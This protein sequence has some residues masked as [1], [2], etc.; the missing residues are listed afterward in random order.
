MSYTTKTVEVDIELDDFDD[1]DIIEYLQERGYVV[2]NGTFLSREEE[3]LLYELYLDYVEG[4]DLNR[5]VKRVLDEMYNYVPL[6]S[7]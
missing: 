7:V 1:N 2:G 6:R 4:K 5:T 3:R